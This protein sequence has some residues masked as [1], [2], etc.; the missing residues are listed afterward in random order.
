MSVHQGKASRY[1]RVNAKTGKGGY[2][3]YYMFIPIDIVRELQL[4][5]DDMLKCFVTEVEGKKGFVCVKLE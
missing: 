5:D 2:I 4:K 3:S 1:A